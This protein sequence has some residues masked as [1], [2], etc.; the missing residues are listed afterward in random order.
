MSGR[1]PEEQVKRPVA[2]QRWRAMT[3]LHW[4]YEPQ[5]VLPLLPDG[6]ELDTYLGQ[7]WVGLTP[8]EMVDFSVGC[9]PPVPGVSTFPETNLRTYVRGP[10]GKDGLWFL[11]LDASSLPTV[12]AASTAYGVPYRWADMSVYE[13]PTVRYRSRRQLGSAA[14]H[15]ITVRPDR[16]FRPEELSDFDHWLTGR[17][18][19]YTTI[20]GR[21]A[22]VPVQHQPWPL[23]R[24]E[25]E[26]LE[27][28][29]LR[30]A[31]L[32]EP[33]SEP[34]VHYSPEVDVRLGA[35]HLG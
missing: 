28:T 3:F 12:V 33:D 24:A 10:D 21:L 14:G 16:P 32:P 13:G 17:W 5:E 23:W 7:A 4:S 6:L 1:E 26:Q 25:V 20:L 29:L 35:P 8:F 15:R 22:T 31:G 18:R 30:A 9:L 2:C 11:S 34:L 19:A 27:E